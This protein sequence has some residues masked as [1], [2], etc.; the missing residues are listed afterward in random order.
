M[1]MINKFKKPIA[2]SS[3]K[4]S[5]LRRWILS[6]KKDT[7]NNVLWYCS[8]FG[9]RACLLFNPRVPYYLTLQLVCLFLFIFTFVKVVK[10][11]C[12]CLHPPSNAYK[13]R[14]QMKEKEPRSQSWYGISVFV[15][16]ACSVRLCQVAWAM[17]Q[18]TW[19]FLEFFIN[20]MSWMQL[21]SGQLRSEEM[22]PGSRLGPWL[23]AVGDMKNCAL[24]IRGYEIA[25]LWES[26]S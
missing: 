17:K 1:T 20:E 16:T 6:G 15:S 25:H 19:S 8:W 21:K 12:M 18:K 4:F 11:W 7:T 13:N 5:H 2:R 24:L 3:N 26:R 14:S 10:Q 22:D 9:S 23:V